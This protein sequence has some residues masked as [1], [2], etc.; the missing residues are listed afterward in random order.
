VEIF[1]FIS[2]F[3]ITYILVAEKAEYGKISIKNFYIRRMLRIWPLYFL[4]IILGPIFTSWMHIGNPNYLANSL[5]YSNF[6]VIH[7]ESWQYPFSH[8][9]SIAIEEQFYLVWPLVIAFFPLPKLKYVFGVLVTAS[10][11]SRAW[12]YEYTDHSWFP[13]FLNPCSRMDTLVI[14][15]WIALLHREGKFNIRLPRM[16]PLILL[17][18]FLLSLF[19]F[20]NA[21]WKNLWS[22]LFKKY[23]YLIPIALLVLNYILNPRFNRQNWMK[24]KLGYLGKVSYGIYLYH[25]ILVIIVIKK[26]LLNNDIFSWTAFALVYVLCSLLMAIISFELYEKW[27][28]QFKKRFERIRTRS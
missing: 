9:W 25:N 28:L 23:L 18:G 27:F 22:A 8:F 20:P 7:S 10:I 11:L 2:G 21:Q 3:L 1:F 16:V 12:F 26:I 4:L 5:F 13:I 6:E 24:E 17:T 14:G 19:F 15:G